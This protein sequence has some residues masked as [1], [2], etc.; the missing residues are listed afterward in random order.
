MTLMETAQLLG[1]FGEFV[2]AIA[3]VATLAYLAVQVNHTRKATEAN[4]RSL[5]ANACW[6]GEIVFAQR[7]EKASRDPE[8]CELYRRAF[9]PDA[10]I[11]SFDVNERTRIMFD[12]LSTLQLVQAQY[13]MW[14]EG[15]LPDEVWE[16]RSIWARRFVLLPVI[17]ALWDETKGEYLL[18]NSFTDYVESIQAQTVAKMP[19]VG[20]TP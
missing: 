16:Y 5:R 17:R 20:S 18:S 11:T 12:V 6:D 3:V 4:T 13:F 10:D 1:N 8:F 15:S 7:N 9:Q 14:R 19:A 2:G